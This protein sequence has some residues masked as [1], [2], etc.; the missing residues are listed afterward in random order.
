MPP[1]TSPIDIEPIKHELARGATVADFIEIPYLGA[2]R[3][4]G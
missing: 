1:L 2:Y 3:I 4:L